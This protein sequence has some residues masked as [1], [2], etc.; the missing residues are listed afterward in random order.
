MKKVYFFLILS[1]CF[2]HAKSQDFGQVL[3]GS[4]QDANK[5][6]NAY[7]QPFAEGEIYNSARGWYSTAIAHKPLGVDLSV[8]FEAAIIPTQQQNFTFNNSD[9]TTFKLHGTT[10]ASLPTFMGGELNP[11]QQIDVSTTVN[12]QSA[13]TSFTAPKGIGNDFKKNISFLPVSAPLPVAQLGIGLIK[14]TDIKLRYFPK[15]NFGNKGNGDDQ[16]GIGIFGIGV[17]HEFTHYL[18]FAKKIPFLHLSALAAYS[19]TKVDYS[20]DM[21]NAGNT[22]TSTDGKISYAISS[23]SFQA[24]ASVKFSLLEIYG[25]LGYTTGKSDIDVKG[26]YKATYNTGYPPPNDKVSS[27]VTNP[28][29]LSYNVSGLSNTWGVRL[30]LAFLKIY[31]DYTIAKYNGI[32]AGIAFSFR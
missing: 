3:A 11:A 16:V 28:I 30:N 19:N 7:L 12:G 8:R 26:T 31:G 21:T 1:V 13:T 17:Q 5:Y 9:Y 27:T 22:V 6:L 24:I 4:T 15:T 29:S 10:T 20:P 25:A 18:P 2:V 32:S 23:F 14:H